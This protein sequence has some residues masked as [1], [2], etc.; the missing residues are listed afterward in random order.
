MELVIA[1]VE[2]KDGNV[3]SFKNF[4]TPPF[5]LGFA[6]TFHVVGDVQAELA[7]RVRKWENVICQGEPVSI[8]VQQADDS[9]LMTR[10]DSLEV[11]F[12]SQGNYRLDILSGE[13][14][15]YSLP[16][17]VF[18]SSK[19]SDLEREIVY[20]LRK[21]RGERSVQEIT[22]GVYNP[23]LLNKANFAEMSGKVYFALLRMTEVTNT[24]PVEYGSLAEKMN[25]SRWKL[26]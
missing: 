11:V 21:K 14:L 18:D 1:S 15:L 5:L 20:Y 26:K 19:R 8:H 7:Y 10:A 25:G 13:A 6:L 2:L 3:L 17:S 24:N 4:P 12:P 22:R 9:R 23:S 16:F